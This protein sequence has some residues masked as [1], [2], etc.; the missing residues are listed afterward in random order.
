MSAYH[1]RDIAQDVG[2]SLRIVLL[3]N[4]F[5]IILLFSQTLGIA[6]IVDVEAESLRKV[7]ETEKAKSVSRQLA[8]PLII[9]MVTDQHCTVHPHRNQRCL[10]PMDIADDR[11]LIDYFNIN[12]PLCQ[13]KIVFFSLW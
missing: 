8:R 13:E 5:Q 7:I 10:C 6:Y 12:E 3:I 4:I 11:P 2:K 1:L 9:F